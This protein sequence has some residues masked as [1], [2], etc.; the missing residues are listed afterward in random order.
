MSAFAGKF[1]VPSDEGFVE[2]AFSRV[3]NH[4]RP[5]DR[6][7]SAVLVAE[8][9]QDVVAGVRFAKENGLAVTVR[10]GGHSWAVWSVQNNTLLIDLEKLNSAEYDEATG[11]VSGGPAIEG[12]NQ[13]DP[14]LAE[15]GRFFNGGHC[16]PVGIG[17]FLLQGGQG[18]CQ[19]GWGWAA[20]SVVAVDVV[21]ADGEL[22]RADAEQNS[23]LYWAARG[24]G[25]SFPGIVTKFHLKTRPRFKHLFHS[26]QVYAISDFAEVMKWMYEVEPTIS[27]DV[28]I[29]CVSMC[30]PSMNGEPRQRVYVVT[31]VALSETAEA[32]QEALA[33]LQT[34]PIIDR[35]FENKVYE[36][37]LA[38]QREDQLRM[39]PENWRYYADNAWIDGDVE[40]VIEALTPVFSTAP[41]PDSFTIWFGNGLMRELP[42]MAFSLQS[43]AYVATYLAYEDSANDARNRAWL[44]EAMVAAQP[45]TV[46]QY[47]GDSDMTNKQLKFMADENFAKLQD[48]IA[49]RDPEG[50]F[51][52]Y[53][54][55]DPANVNKNHWQL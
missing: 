19:R 47:L 41:E 4:R 1:Y 30:P 18:W 50:R 10:S 7:P 26:V 31:G 12:G 14:F 20:E 37:S 28:E 22:V 42:D 24:A 34:C 29:V 36:S 44:N 9:E 55:K 32:A 17:G 52:R 39:N 48:I 13:L 21:T 53:L 38:E 40:D 23:D 33:P 16:P 27:P 54:A 11:I 8:N 15:R 49:K 43:P 5:T 2:A 35:A 46:G 25:P 45:V 3:F 6:L 51:V